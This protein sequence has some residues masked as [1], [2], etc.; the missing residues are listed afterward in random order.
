MNDFLKKILLYLIII[1]H[2][3]FVYFMILGFLLPRKYLY[4]FL[5]SW[6]LVYIHWNLN[7]NKCILTEWEYKLKNIK[8]VPIVNKD[9]DFPFI[10]KML[11]E[12]N[13]YLSNNQIHYLIISLLT[14]TWT[15]GLIRFYINNY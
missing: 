10:N 2:K 3:L 4:L 15:I 11:N 1:I 13:I 7:N 9:H 8:D 12:W 6:P 14:I 5:I